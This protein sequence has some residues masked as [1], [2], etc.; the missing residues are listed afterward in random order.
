MASSARS[1]YAGC[2][3]VA[4]V[5]AVTGTIFAVRDYVPVLSL[6][7]LYLPAVLAVAVFFG[8]VFA[9]AVSVASM[10]AFNFFF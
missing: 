3:S 10:V 8:L 6:G 1:I 5:A 7:V 4:A 9:V 2:F